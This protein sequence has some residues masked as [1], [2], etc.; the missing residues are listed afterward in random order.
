MTNN[1]YLAQIKVKEK[2]SIPVT[3]KMDKKKMNAH[4]WQ[5]G[6]LVAGNWNQLGLT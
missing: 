6:F 1:N 5:S 2:Y 4:P 3:W